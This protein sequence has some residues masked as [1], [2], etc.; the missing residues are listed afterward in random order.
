MDNGNKTTSPQCRFL[1]DDYIGE[2]Y[3]AFT[4][5][6]SDYVIPF[7]LTETQFRNHINLNA[8]DLTRTVGSLDNGRLVGFTLNGFGDWNGRPTAYDAGTGVIPA[9]RRR[10]LSRAMF[11]MMTPIFRASGIE[12]FL[13]EVVTTNSGAIDLYEKLGFVA[14]RRLA[15][16][17]CDG[18]IRESTVRDVSIR[19]INEPDW[20]LFA[21]FWDGKPSWQN[22]IDAIKRCSNLRRIF[23]A[24]VDGQC[25][26]Y[27]IFASTLGRVA[28]IAVSKAHRNRGIATALVKMMQDS[29]DQDAPLQVINIDTTLTDTMNFFNNLG[30][31]ERLNQHEMVKSI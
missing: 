28:Q 20:E 30:F 3:A 12:Q 17:Q 13:L 8:V 21:T 4:E 14:V 5:A 19:E 9:Y 22:S 23:A 10:G 15:L 1:N 24:F 27:I 6:F 25:V 11:D 26:G 29:T 31:N 18:K 7:A 16:L 2:L